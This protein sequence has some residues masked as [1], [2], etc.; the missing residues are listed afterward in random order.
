[1]MQ[2]EVTFVREVVNAYGKR[3]EMPLGTISVRAAHSRE[4]A[5][6]AAVKRFERKHR[7][8]RWDLLA[9]TYRLKDIEAE[10]ATEAP[11]RPGGL[12]VRRDQGAACLGIELSQHFLRR[13][14]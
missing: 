12:P 11:S 1:M 3:C 14:S 5:A 7:L 4:R 2:Y 9:Q 13:A 10:A 6:A 8:A